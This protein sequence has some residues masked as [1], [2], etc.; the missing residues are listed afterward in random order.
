[1][2]K[3][4]LKYWL[5][6][7]IRIVGR[8]FYKKHVWLL[9]DRKSA[10]GDNGEAMFKYLQSKDIN[11]IFAISKNSP[12][13]EKMAR[14]GKV[15]D[16]DSLYYK[17]LLCVCDV[18]LSSQM[19]H[20]E[21]HRETFQVFLQHGVTMDDMHSM[22]NPASHEN[23]YIVVSG[24]QEYES[25]AQKPYILKKKNIL[26]TGLPRFDYRKDESE[27]KILISF[28]WRQNLSA[29]KK[30]DFVK[31]DYYRAYNSIFNDERIKEASEKYGYKILFK[32]HP[33]MN[34]FMSSFNV[35]D[36]VEIADAGYTEL[37]NK[38]KMLVTDYSSLAFD[39][40]H[41]GKNVINYIFDFDSFWNSTHFR[42]KGYYD[43]E[44]GLGICAKT[45][46]EF[47]NK[48]ISCMENDCRL[49]KNQQERI[50]DFF[51][52]ID[53]NNCER[54]YEEVCKILK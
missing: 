46:E 19:I 38:C 15:V 31:S 4:N 36:W 44:N 13:Y 33:E 11:S 5:F 49:S 2:N 37:I 43:Y 24:R 21:T 41:L 47:V 32:L 8:F 30:E 7:T 28:T 26:L 52:Y 27:K 29:C 50:K 18:H 39:F 17:F 51:A 23:F 12:D 9:S 34:S 35:P 3:D 25:M 45:H 54:V 1:M 20:M 42:S 22:I 48:L 6:R 10:A 14:I 53:K 40:S 16:Y